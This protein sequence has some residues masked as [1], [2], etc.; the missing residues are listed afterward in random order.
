MR[1][2]HQ[3]YTP[4]IMSH[5]S[6]SS[7]FGH[8]TRILN[9]LFFFFFFFLIFNF[10]LLILFIRHYCTPLSFPK[11]ISQRLDKNKIKVGKIWKEKKS[12]WEGERWRGFLLRFV[13]NNCTLAWFSRNEKHQVVKRKEGLLG[14]YNKRGNDVGGV[15]V[16]GIG[17][18]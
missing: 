17:C 13:K 1:L 18:L 15:A 12:K 4:I 6:Q 9:F 3:I 2:P 11:E 14:L 16:W 5:H 10:L 7:L 8:D